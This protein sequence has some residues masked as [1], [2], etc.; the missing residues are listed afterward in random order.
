MNF[1]DILHPK[2]V[3]LDKP[4]F[5]SL[6]KNRKKNDIWL[7]DFFAPWCG[8]CQALAPEWRKLAKVRESPIMQ[9]DSKL[10]SGWLIS[11]HSDVDSAGFTAGLVGLRPR[12]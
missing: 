5:D 1:Q 12:A 9:I 7:V 11:M 10:T 2:V 6:V 4:L 8:P 3:T